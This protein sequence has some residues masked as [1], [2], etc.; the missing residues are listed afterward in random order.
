MKKKKNW[1]LGYSYDF[2]IDSKSLREFL[3]KT[4]CLRNFLLMKN[5]V[6]WLRILSPDFN[7]EEII[8]H[9]GKDS[10]IDFK[11]TQT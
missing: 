8:D 3:K 2:D 7:S 5:F 9:S 4:D 1:V 11:P 6:D 10:S